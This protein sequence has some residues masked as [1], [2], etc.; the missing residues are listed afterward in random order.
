M[1]VLHVIPSIAPVHGGASRAILEMTKALQEQGVK[2][3]IV[4]T[5]D[6]GSDLLDVPLQKCI[7]YEQVPVWFFPRFSPPI[8]SVRGF[9]FSS[10]LTTWLWRHIA[11]YNIIHVYGMFSYVSTLAMEIARIKNIPYIIRPQGQ[12]GEWALQQRTF[13]KQIYITLIQRA[14]LNC[15]RAV[16]FTSEQEQEETSKLNLKSP[17]FVLRNG[18]FVPPPI[19]EA[20]YKLRQLLKVPEDEPVILFLSRLHP[21]K[22]LDYLIP[23]LGKVANRRFTFVVAG[24]GSPEY[25]DTIDTL[26]V[27]AGI[28]DRTYRAGFVSGEMKDLLLQ[29]ADLFALTSYSEN[30]GI[31]VLEAMAAGKPVLATSGVALASVVKQYQ[32]GY[33][34]ELD[35]EAIALFVQDF[36]NCPQQAKKMGDR[37]RKLIAEQYTWERIATKMVEIYTDIILPK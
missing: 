14:N 19:P 36:L 23:A 13:K 35:V 33:V 2:A 7:E 16:H 29:G 21:K 24:S 1:K 22:G 34:A 3:E 28:R 11:E 27:S 18:L 30:F 17:S 26:L 5:N 8:D 20:G 32:L 6:N 37:A 25:E 12:L 15:S 9:V 4:T 31:A 10:Q